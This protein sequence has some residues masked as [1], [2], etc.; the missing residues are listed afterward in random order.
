MTIAS[1]GVGTHQLGDKLG[2]RALWRYA[3]LGTLLPVLGVQRVRCM[4]FWR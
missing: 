2:A 4:E 1:A 3:P